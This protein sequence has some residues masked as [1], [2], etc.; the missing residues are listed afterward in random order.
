MAIKTVKKLGSP[1][2]PEPVT[3]DNAKVKAPPTSGLPTQPTWQ[4]KLGIYQTD[5]EATETELKRAQDK[6]NLQKAT[7][8]TKGYE[9]SNRWIGQ[10]NTATGQS[11][12]PKVQ[13]YND[14]QAKQK[15]LMGKFEGMMNQPTTYN[16]EVDPRYQAYKTLYEKQAKKASQNAM[17]TTN[18]RGIL[19]STITSDRLGQIEQDAQGN[20]MAAIPEFYAQDQIS[21]QNKM[22]NVSE[23]LGF[24]TDQAG[25]AE[26]DINTAKENERIQIENE[27]Q[28]ELDQVAAEQEAQQT[29][30]DNLWKAAEQTGVLPNQLADAYGLP[31][32]TSTLE[33]ARVGVSQQNADTS[34]INAGTSQQNANTSSRNANTSATSTANSNN[35]AR[36]NQ[37]MDAWDRTGFA[38]A[39]LESLGVEEGTTLPQKTQETKALG[40]SDY[41]TNPEFGSDYSFIVNNPEEA[42]KLLKENAADFIETYGYDGY[43]A[44]LDGLPD[45]DE[46]ELL[47]LLEE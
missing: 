41:K 46:N 2:L 12:D 19:N 28:I 29:E 1:A 3:V 8:D 42:K 44:L 7:G 13:Q 45:K 39:G 9:A 47:K 40:A 6:A 10:I 16:P 17:E 33:A 5:S 23:L 35:N 36:I 11:S 37:L 30:L 14:Y 43:K 34:R 4:E 20:A 31:Q 22:K 27:R 24:V 26:D 32:G 38:P 15:E 21:Q 18:E 25:N